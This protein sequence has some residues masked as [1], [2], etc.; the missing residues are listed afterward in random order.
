[1]LIRLIL[2]LTVVP[3]AELVVLLQVH[4]AIAEAFGTGVGLLVTVGS[5]A[6][7]GVAGAALARQ[8]GLGVLRDLQQRLGRGEIPGQTITDGVLILI[9]A[10]LL[11]TPGFLTDL[12]GFSLLIPMSRA[13]WRRVLKQRFQR[14]VQSGNASVI[15]VTPTSSTTTGPSAGPAR[16]PDIVGPAGN[17]PRDTTG[18]DLP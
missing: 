18:Q 17:I 4:H 8:Q 15:F 16:E 2:L 6:A 9:G 12:C 5:I 10:A 11:L 3:I 14:M 1:M 7:T 13:I